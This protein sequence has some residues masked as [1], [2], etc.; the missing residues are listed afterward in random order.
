MTALFSITNWLLFAVLWLLLTRLLV[1][2]WAR[3]GA[4]LAPVLTFGVLLLAYDV[5]TAGI[6]VVLMLLFIPTLARSPL[7]AGLMRLIVA[8]TDPLVDLVRRGSGGRIAGGPAIVIAVL[9]VIALRI[10]SFLALRA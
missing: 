5:L 2:N 3:G 7:G 4:I 9:L 1:L 6:A 8:L 10:A